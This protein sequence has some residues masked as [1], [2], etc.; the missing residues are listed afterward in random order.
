MG[1]REW[2]C[3]PGADNLYED[4]I[5]RHVPQNLP[6]SNII[7]LFQTMSNQDILQTS[8]LLQICTQHY[9]IMKIFGRCGSN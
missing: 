5:P 9:L 7:A 3:T 6:K 1:L 2:G 4:L 8:I